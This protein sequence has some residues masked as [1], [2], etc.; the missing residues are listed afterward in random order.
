[1]TTIPTKSDEFMADLRRAYR[2]EYER[3]PELKAE[4]TEAADFA[5]YMV[6]ENPAMIQKMREHYEDIMG[7]AARRRALKAGLIHT[8][9]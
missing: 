9:H 7:E 1:M 5:A 6:A 3:S 8:R 4:F 2:A